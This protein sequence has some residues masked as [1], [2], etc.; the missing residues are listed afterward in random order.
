MTTDGSDSTGNRFDLMGFGET[1]VR[2]AAPRGLRLAEANLLELTIGGAESNVAV[3]L[4]SLGRR[5][6]WVSALPRHP[7][8]NRIATELQALG[9]DTSLVR[10]SDRGR[11]GTYFLEHGVAPRPAR[12][13]YDRA[14]SAIALLSG[15][16]IDPQIVRYARALHLT[17]ITPALGAGCAAICDALA[18][19]AVDQGIPVVFDVN[20]RSRLWSPR[21]ARSGIEPLVQR[22]SLLLCGQA[23]AASIWGLH[24][25][26]EEIAARLHDLCGAE[27][28]VV[29]LGARG[30]VAR[31][32]DGRCVT[33]PALP[34]DTIDPVGAGD[35]FAA[36]FI[37]RWLDDP[38]DVAGALRAASA[39][40]ALKMTVWGDHAAFSRAELD[41]AMALF[42]Q[43]G[44]DIDR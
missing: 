29:T 24:G 19:A 13:Y 33:S 43:Q 42:E 7:L 38:T 16:D 37:D 26:G 36:G 21:E 3:A 2:L 11:V 32:R 15:R 9:V 4:A 14:G 40:A 39:L 41:E 27:C 30:A 10:W 20:Y 6:A 35:A 18:S 5:V 25:D 1:M 34:V 44:T 12:V 23:D 31:R 8:G 28:V 22:A 17:G